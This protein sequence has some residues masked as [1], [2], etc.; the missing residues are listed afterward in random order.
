[1]IPTSPRATA[2][3]TRA[4]TSTTIATTLSTPIH[5]VA[6]LLRPLVLAR[7]RRAQEHE[8]HGQRCD[9]TADDERQPVPEERKLKIR[10]PIA[11]LERVERRRYEP[12]SEQAHEHRRYQRGRKAQ[13]PQRPGRNDLVDDLDRGV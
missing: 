7:T 6:T 4:I 10:R 1:M 9:D 2:T 8:H 5:S 13:P 12:P 11:D 3:G